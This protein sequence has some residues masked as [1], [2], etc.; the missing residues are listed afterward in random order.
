MTQRILLY[1]WYTHITY[2]YD[3]LFSNI[4]YLDISN[5]LCKNLKTYSSLLIYLQLFTYSIFYLYDIL[6]LFGD[7][8]VFLYVSGIALS[9]WYHQYRRWLELSFPV[10]HDSYDASLEPSTHQQIIYR[11]THNTQYLI[12]NNIMLSNTVVMLFTIV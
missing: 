11:T 3:N 1:T 2:H 7:T 9:I 10:F 12:E 8:F 4:W 6:F 5:K